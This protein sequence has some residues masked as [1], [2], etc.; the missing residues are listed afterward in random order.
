MQRACPARSALLLH[1]FQELGGFGDEY[2][3]FGWRAYAF[4]SP[5]KRTPVNRNGTEKW[6]TPSVTNSPRKK[7]PSFPRVVGAALAIGV[8][9]GVRAEVPAG[10][11]HSEVA[12]VE[13]LLDDAF[14][15]IKGVHDYRGVLRKKE[16]FKG[17]LIEQRIAF[18][19]SR[20]FRIYLRYV[21]PHA[22]QEVIYIRGHNKGRLRA[23]RGSGLDV[24]VSLNPRGRMAMAEGHHPVT[25]FGIEHM[26]ELAARDIRRAARGGG[27]TLQLSDGGQINGEPTWRIDLRNP[28]GGRVLIARRGE[29]LWDL[30]AR[31]KQDMYVILHQNEG[32]DSPADVR[33][34]QE[35]FVPHY[36]AG[37]GQYFIS[38]QTH[39]LI[40]LVMWDHKGQLYE[41][42]EYSKLELNTGLDAHDFDY[43]NQEYEFVRHDGR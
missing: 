17:A 30:A 4:V 33:S 15:A 34:G 31:A 18:K 8:A 40:K 3:S 13:A 21:E 10:T 1:G 37:R 16:L 11:S 43:R 28:S 41:V 29:T 32:I 2:V 25:E 42:Y 7:R 36:Y 6:Y 5:R 39:L 38:K 12:R 35:V 9:G 22:G 14:Q 20:P 24:T 19:F 26:L 27:A 23:H